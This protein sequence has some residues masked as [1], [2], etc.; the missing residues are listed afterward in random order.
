[1]DS[2]K[3]Y[4]SFSDELTST[5]SK[6][7]DKVAPTRTACSSS[8]TGYCP[9]CSSSSAVIAFDISLGA[10]EDV[11]VMA[12]PM[13]VAPTAVIDSLCKPY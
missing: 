6:N 9:L 2:R 8:S 3:A 5:E 4:I 13:F 12:V 1:M 7:D 10:G 11:S